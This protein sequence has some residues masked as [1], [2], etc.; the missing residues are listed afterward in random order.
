M[1]RRLETMVNRRIQ[2]VVEARLLE[3]SV[4]L[5]QGPRSVGKSTL[6][7]AIAKRYQVPIIDLDEIATKDA[8]A[9]DPTLFMGG[10]SPVL[11]DEYQKVPLILNAIKA[12][13]R[14]KTAPGRFLLTG[15]TRHEALP[16]IAEALSGRLHLM[17]I[18]PLTQ[19]ELEGNKNDLLEKL[20]NDPSSAIS[21]SSSHTKRED[22]VEKLLAGGF[23]LALNRPSTASRNR[24]ID[25]YV[26]LTLENDA[27]SITK[28]RQGAALENVL[29]QLAGQTGQILNMN[30]VAHDLGYA[31]DLVQRHTKLLQDVFLV[32]KLDAWG[33][34]LSSRSSSLPKIHVTDSAI[35]ARLLRLTSTKLLSRDATALTEFGHLLESFVVNEIIR[36]VSWMDGISGV[37]HWRTHD[38]EE[39]DLVIELDDGGVVVFE[40]KSGTRVADAD[41][42]HMKTLRDKL[43]G[44]FKAGVAFHLGERSYTSMDRIHVMPV[45]RL[46]L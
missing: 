35:A 10:A 30:K 44:N 1:A 45:D 33:K 31:K 41:L 39:I 6:L 3:E 25:D 14:T 32:H 16:E 7:N 13:L 2:A 43:G 36:K 15:S 26:K 38:G 42:K 23:P 20:I 37:G 8:V 40:V 11:V 28:F 9:S 21:A 24:W 29:M 22:Y 12:E 18:Y 46:W 5:L 4:L 34:T 19:E 17:Q 27:R